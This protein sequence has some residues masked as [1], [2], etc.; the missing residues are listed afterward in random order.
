MDLKKGREGALLSFEGTKRNWGNMCG[1][2]TAAMIF[3]VS[4]AF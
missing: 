4:K 1:I 2:I 3:Y